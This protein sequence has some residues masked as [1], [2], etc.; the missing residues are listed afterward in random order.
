MEQVALSNSLDKMQNK[1]LDLTYIFETYYKR[2][3]NYIYYRVNSNEEAEDLTSQVFGKVMLK[4]DTYSKSKS[5]FEVWMFAIARNVVNDYFRSLKK[6]RLFSIDK[7][8]ELM[9]RENNPE[10]IVLIAETNDKL[11]KALKVL[12]SKER[13]IV[14]LKFGGNLK[15]KEIAEILDFTESNVGVILYRVMK[16][17][18]V[19]MEREV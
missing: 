13:N 11:S 19:E 14:A 17:L 3:Y 4:I 10:D 15:N 2:I 16:K 5:P 18:K 6:H 1:E 12:N 7:I 8:K 9:S